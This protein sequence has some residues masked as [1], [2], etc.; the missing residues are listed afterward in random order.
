MI[1]RQDFETGLIISLV[2]PPLPHVVKKVDRLDS[3]WPIEWTLRGTINNKAYIQGNMMAMR[4]ISDAVDYDYEKAAVAVTVLPDSGGE[5]VFTTKNIG[6]TDWELGVLI[7]IQCTYNGSSYILGL[8]VVKEA[9]TAGMVEFDKGT[10]YAFMDSS[11]QNIQFSNADVRFE[12][13]APLPTAYSYNGVI[14]PKLPEWDRESY[15]Y[16]VMNWD[17][18]GGGTYAV[19]LMVSSEP[20]TYR[21]PFI[22]TGTGGFARIGDIQFY[23]L[24]SDV[25]WWEWLYPNVDPSTTA[26]TWAFSSEV[27]YDEVYEDASSG[28]EWSNYDIVNQSTGE[29]YLTA[30]KPEPVYE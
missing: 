22:L 21:T 8:S 24:V 12:M 2:S 25:R 17:D 6:V 19:T 7:Y 5:A 10:Y 13:T 20:L 28:H 15:P 23:A 16:A 29:M 26:N 9:G 11:F 27:H 18:K 3:E 1:D 4:R 30:S 14:L